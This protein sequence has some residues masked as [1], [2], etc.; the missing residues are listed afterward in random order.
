MF[1]IYLLINCMPMLL[2]KQLIFRTMKF[3]HRYQLRRYLYIFSF[4][5]SLATT[6]GVLNRQYNN[7]CDVFRNFAVGNSNVNASS[8]HVDGCHYSTLDIF[9]DNRFKSQKSYKSVF[10]YTVDCSIKFSRSHEIRSTRWYF[11]LIRH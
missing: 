1:E 7:P 6:L 11:I 3:T 8:R 9:Y 10:T 2:M 5:F 4:Y